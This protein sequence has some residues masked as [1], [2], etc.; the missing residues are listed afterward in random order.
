VKRAGSLFQ[1][2]KKKLREFRLFAKDKAK[3]VRMIRSSV[4]ASTILTPPGETR[5]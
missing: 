2:A 5:R 1:T 4:S 3:A